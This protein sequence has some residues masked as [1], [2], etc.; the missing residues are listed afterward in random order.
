MGQDIVRGDKY[1]S[2]GANSRDRGRDMRDKGRF[3]AQ[4]SEVERLVA[5]LDFRSDPG[6]ALFTGHLNRWGYAHHTD[7]EGRTVKAH[8]RM[9]ELFRGPI[10]L[11]MTLDHLCG[12]PACGWPWH[13]EP[14]TNSENLRRRHARRRAQNGAAA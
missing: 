4:A 11:G 9:Y 7:A 2:A 3:V 1:R 12:R 5:R 6:H 10:P 8:R 13:L 14:V